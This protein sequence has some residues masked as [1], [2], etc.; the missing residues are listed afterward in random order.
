MKQQP[1][2]SVGGGPGGQ[3]HWQYP[4]RPVERGGGEVAPAGLVS[5]T[6]GTQPPQRTL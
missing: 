5:G 2:L 1:C 6:F 4:S 3:K